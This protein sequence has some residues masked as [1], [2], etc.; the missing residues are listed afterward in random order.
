M[1]YIDQKSRKPLD[2]R[3]SSLLAYID[4]NGISGGD[5]N[6]LMTKLANAYLDKHG[7][8]YSII[9]DVIGTFECAKLEFYRRVAAG[10]EDKKISQNGDVY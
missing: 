10:Y 1:P 9:K 2:D 7:T 8:S 5:L 4:F 6:Y 3:L